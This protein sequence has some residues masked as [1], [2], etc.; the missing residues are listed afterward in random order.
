MY[1]YGACFY[2]CCGDYVGVCVN[3]RRVVAVVNDS[4]LTLEC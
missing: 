4:V 3:V 1:V 2:V